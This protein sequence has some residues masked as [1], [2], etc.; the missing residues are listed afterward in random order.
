M[1]WNHHHSNASANASKPTMHVVT[2]TPWNNQFVALADV[3][4]AVQDVLMDS[5]E[6]EQPS[7][8]H[9]LSNQPPS[10]NVLTMESPL[11]GNKLTLAH[12]TGL[13]HTHCCKWV[14]KVCTLTL[15]FNQN[16]AMASPL[17]EPTVALF[18]DSALFPMNAL[19]SW[20]IWFSHSGKTSDWEVLFLMHNVIGDQQKL[21]FH[22][23]LQASN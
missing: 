19:S 3:E 5:T 18:L 7:W 12:A 20:M 8:K 21:E 10:L 16:E 2:L 11:N 17:C 23:M 13:D 9:N 1:P 22:S 4:E 15:A 14:S 6:F